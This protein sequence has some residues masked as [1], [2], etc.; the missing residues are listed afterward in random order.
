MEEGCDERRSR[1]RDTFRFQ[2][3]FEQRQSLAVI[4]PITKELI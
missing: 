1:G 2:L 3:M 4:L